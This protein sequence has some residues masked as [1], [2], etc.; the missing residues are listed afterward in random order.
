MN[1]YADPSGGQPAMGP[2]RTFGEA[3]ACQNLCIHGQ[4]YNP[5]NLEG[6]GKDVFIPSEWEKYTI[7]YDQSKKLDF[8]TSFEKA[9]NTN[10]KNIDFKN[11]LTIEE[12]C[13]QIF[14][15]C[16]KVSKIKQ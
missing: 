10:V 12:K 1:H 4:T 15:K 6:L 5:N 14:K 7:V 3:I 8:N 9:K 11:A 2:S 13:D 16:L